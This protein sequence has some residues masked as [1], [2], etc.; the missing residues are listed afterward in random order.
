MYTGKYLL[1]LLLNVLILMI[2]L[3]V[4]A[5]KSNK[6]NDTIKIVVHKTLPLPIIKKS[7]PSKKKVEYQGSSRFKI[8]VC[9]IGK[10]FSSII[11]RIFCSL[12]SINENRNKVCT[13]NNRYLS[14]NAM[15]KDYKVK[16]LSN[17]FKKY[18]M[19]MIVRNPIDRLISGFMQ[20]CYYRIYLKPSEDYC[21]GCGKNLTCFINNLQDELWSV[22]ENKKIPDQFFD[23]H[24]YP[25][26]WQCEYYKYKDKYKYLKYSEPNM[27]VFYKNIL[28]YL[29]SAHVPKEHL[30]YLKKFLQSTKTDH[31]TSSKNAT[32]EYKSYLYNNTAL[33]KQVCSMFYYDFIEFGFEIPK[34]CIDKKIEAK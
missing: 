2:N 31:V 28:A 24:Y 5:T 4:Y 34:D 19:L 17:F 13:D 1:I 23:Y 26:T 30:K 18:Q 7:F 21:F 15:A 22:A 14:I 12:N 25:Q 3:E 9:L 11:V 10:N 8:G 27:K 33:L 6:K 20:L 32:N 16:K 29:K